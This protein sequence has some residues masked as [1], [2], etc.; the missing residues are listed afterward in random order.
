MRALRI[1][2]SIAAALGAAA[3]GGEGL[4]P[5]DTNARSSASQGEAGSAPNEGR[6][7]NSPPREGGAGSGRDQEWRPEEVAELRGRCE[8]SSID[9]GLDSPRA[10]VLCSCA[11]RR[12]TELFS[13]S[14]LNDGLPITPHELRT[15]S[16]VYLRCARKIAQPD[17]AEGVSL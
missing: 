16:G 7:A 8:A 11:I 5:A 14:W 3:A 10:H 2:F 4:S 12:L 13:P 17:R 6:I 1:L 15:V 9:Q